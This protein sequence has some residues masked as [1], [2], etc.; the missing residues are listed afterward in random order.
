MKRSH[1]LHAM[2]PAV[3]VRAV[4]AGK[5]DHTAVILNNLPIWRTRDPQKCLP[6]YIIFNRGIGQNT[7]VCHIHVC[8]FP[9]VLIL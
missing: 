7:M 4:K 3:E 2:N 6:L 9:V 8:I 1:Q 5:P